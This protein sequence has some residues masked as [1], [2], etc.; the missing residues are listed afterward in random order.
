MT[1]A[2]TPAALIPQ[3]GGMCLLDEIAY[4]DDTRVTCRSATHRRA[5][6]PLRRDGVLEAVHLLEYAAQAA[7]VHAA[8]APASA[9]GEPRIGYLASARG[10]RL[11]VDRIDD[12]Q[13][14]LR[15]DATR[16]LA[17]GGGAVYEFRVT[18]GRRLLGEGRLGVASPHGGT[19]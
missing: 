2:P 11:H 18:A 16:L 1:A 4:W 19:C 9:A 3:S 5:N 6:H 12:L 10:F 15:I 8:L 7:A 13:T 14:D 17:M